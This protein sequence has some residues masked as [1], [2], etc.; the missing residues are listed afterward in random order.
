MEREYGSWKGG[1]EVKVEERWAEMGESSRSGSGLR[2]WWREERV[3][4]VMVVIVERGG[5]NGEEEDGYLLVFVKS[6][7]VI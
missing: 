2:G 1:E 4:V 6:G 5:D 3:V 7:D